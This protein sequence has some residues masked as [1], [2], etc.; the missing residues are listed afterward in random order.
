MP[1]VATQRT[2][3]T[4][5]GTSTST[6][7]GAGTATPYDLQ[8][9]TRLPWPHL[10]DTRLFATRISALLV[11]TL[12]ASGLVSRQ[13]NGQLDDLHHALVQGAA[14]VE[15]DGRSVHDETPL[16]QCLRDFAA[17][18]AFQREYLQLVRHCRDEV[19]REDFVFEAVPVIRAVLPHELGLPE[20]RAPDGRLVALH[21]D[22]LYHDPAGQVN[23]WMA[24]TDCSGSRALRM[25]SLAFGVN[26]LR[27]FFGGRSTLTRIDHDARM[28]FFHFLVADPTRLN[29]ALADAVPVSTPPGYTRLF[30]MRR[31][32]GTAD[33]EE[34]G[35]RVSMD[36]RMVPIDV[37]EA[38][39]QIPGG[40]PAYAEVPLVCGGFYHPQVASEIG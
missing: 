28:R 40:P 12:A 6:S 14:R 31:L 25:G 34:Q 35:T 8:R 26:L 23:A 37:Y 3:T 29:Q 21:T 32:H 24:L 5:A 1:L 38:L 17:S 2:R 19:L 22:M 36:F 11:R 16:M 33:N 18:D 30:D 7:T 27:E 10:V 4:G 15:A 20:L 9:A 13:W 39:Q